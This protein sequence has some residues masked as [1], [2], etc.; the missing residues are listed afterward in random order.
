MA[1]P[2]AQVQHRAGLA[3]EVPTDESEVVGVY[4]LGRTEHPDIKLR[5]RR[6]CLPDLVHTHHVTL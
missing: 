3:R 4:L 6:I 1:G 5:D 2:T